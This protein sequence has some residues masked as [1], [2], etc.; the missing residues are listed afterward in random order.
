MLMRKLVIATNNQ[1]KCREIQD[2]LV[3][4]PF[5]VLSLKDIDLVIEVE[6]DQDSFDGNAKKK[7]YEIMKASGE[8]ALAD[9][10]GL[11]VEA[12]DCKPGV[13]S[14]MF[15]GYGASDE[16]N[17][18]KLLTLMKDFTTDQRKAS[19][20][21][22]IAVAYTDG[23]IIFAKETCKGRIAVSPTG[24]SGFGYDPVFIPENCNKSFAQMDKKEKNM[25]SHRGKALRKI[26]QML[27]QEFKKD[28]CY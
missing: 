24:N 3:D 11:E 1:G 9:D 6:E 7:A 13:Y 20:C 27:D 17:Y 19:F 4:L 21:C 2:M 28:G 12:L 5:C 15:A 16:E 25:I 8:I 23:R 18:T 22:V 14:A 10:S 26:K